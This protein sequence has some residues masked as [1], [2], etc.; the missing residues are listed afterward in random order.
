MLFNKTAILSK[1]EPTYSAYPT[2]KKLI[3]GN[4]NTTTSISTL[5][6]SVRIANKETLNNSIRISTHPNS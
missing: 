2:R 4:A 1:N 5:E 6:K 3:N